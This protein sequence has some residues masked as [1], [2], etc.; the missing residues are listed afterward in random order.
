VPHTT[1]GCGLALGIDKADKD[2]EPRD[3]E[4]RLL[5]NAVRWLARK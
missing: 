4:L 2:T 1:V 3:A 5:V